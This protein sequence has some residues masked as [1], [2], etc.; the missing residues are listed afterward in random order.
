MKLRWGFPMDNAFVA[1]LAL[2]RPE[3]PSAQA[4]IA[5]F[6]R[7]VPKLPFELEAVEAPEKRTGAGMVHAFKAGDRLLSV[8]LI[9]KPLPAGTLD[10]AIQA[11]LVWPE[12][13]EK[14]A[15]H[16]AHIIV[17]CVAGAEG[18]GPAID[19][20]GLVTA[21][22]AVI[23][24]L[25][26]TIGVYWSTGNTVTETSR[27]QQVA[28]SFFA[29]NPPVTVWVQLLMMPSLQ[30]AQGEPTLAAVTQGLQPFV[31]REIEF[32]PSTLPP[33]AIAQRAVGASVY[34]L[35]KGPVLKDGDTL[36]IS[37]GE[38]IRVAYA[39]QGCRPGIPVMKLS[40]EHLGGA[41]GVARR[42][43]GFGPAG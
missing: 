21:M 26:P 3:I 34:L 36:G 39:D 31:G 37:E 43:D 24:T 20:A 1:M 17:G 19:T 11:D 12:A 4:I 13:K 10:K 8:M 9:D 42:P 30:T 2:S 16:K 29:G 27:F 7:R 35:A 38:R 32:Q 15:A 22:A 5:E 41:G 33:A 6:E 14:L 23:A 40:L 25:T 18:Y 28:D